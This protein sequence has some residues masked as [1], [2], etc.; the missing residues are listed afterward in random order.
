MVIVFRDTKRHEIRHRTE[1]PGTKAKSAG[2][3]PGAVKVVWVLVVG[4][5]RCHCLSPPFPLPRP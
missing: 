1:P 3:E 2:M 5:N 4:E